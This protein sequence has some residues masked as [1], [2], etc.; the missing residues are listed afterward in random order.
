[1][2]NNDNIGLQCL[3][4]RHERFDRSVDAKEMKTKDCEETACAF[5]TMITKKN[6]PTK[7][8]VDKGAENAG[9]LKKLSKAER[10]KIYS[11]LSETEAAFAEVTKRS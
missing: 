4:V 9:E 8:W 10:I 5:L 6:R 1:M 3:L 11:T 2:V 7:T